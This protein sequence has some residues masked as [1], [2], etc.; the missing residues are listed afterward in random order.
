MVD[1][2]LI[3]C[4]LVYFSSC[5]CRTVSPMALMPFAIASLA[6]DIWR[7]DSGTRPKFENNFCFICIEIV[8]KLLKLYGFSIRIVSAT[9][10][11]PAK[12]MLIQNENIHKTKVFFILLC[13]DKANRWG[14]LPSS[15]SLSNESL[16]E[17]SPVP[18]SLVSNKP[19]NNEIVWNATFYL[20]L[21]AH[22][23]YFDFIYS[24]QNAI[25]FSVVFLSLHMIF[26]LK[27]KAIKEYVWRKFIRL[28]RNDHPARRNTTRPPLPISNPIYLFLN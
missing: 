16:I 23:V 2:P 24:N 15:N 21:C 3:H 5:H 26:D 7:D 4:S 18:L 9:F 12:Q 1:S 25:S 8:F 6:C 19:N 20:W 28:H 17:L 13:C 10:A 11:K 14:V 22:R 27:A